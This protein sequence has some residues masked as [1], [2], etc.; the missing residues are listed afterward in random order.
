MIS[1]D[2]ALNINVQLVC[3]NQ[4]SKLKI[5]EI[6]VAPRTH[7]NLSLS[8]GKIISRELY[9]TVVKEVSIF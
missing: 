7:V 1:L 4:N 8:I 2:N 9:S 5:S 6:V 3:E